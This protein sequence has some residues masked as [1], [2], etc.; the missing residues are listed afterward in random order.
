[1]PMSPISPQPALTSPDVCSQSARRADPLRRVVLRVVT[2]ALPGLAVWVFTG[3][4]DTAVGR[5]RRAVAAGNPTLQ[6]RE[7]WVLRHDDR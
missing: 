7:G 2:G 6:L 5:D 1:M 3:R 4:L